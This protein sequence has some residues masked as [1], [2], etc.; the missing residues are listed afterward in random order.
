MQPLWTKK[1]H[2]LF[3]QKKSCN[4][5]GQKHYATSWDK[6]NH[7]TSQDKKNH[8]TSVKFLSGHFELV[9]LPWFSFSC[10]CKKQSKVKL[11]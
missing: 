10:K 5:L 7:A 3:E 8:A 4:L 11:F 6:K 9:S 2:N 1:S